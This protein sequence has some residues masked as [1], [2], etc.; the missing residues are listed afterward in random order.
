MH[1]L[2]AQIIR[3][4]RFEGL[5]GLGVLVQRCVHPG[6]IARRDFLEGSLQ[7]IADFLLD[8]DSVH[9]FIRETEEMFRLRRPQIFPEK[10]DDAAGAPIG[11]G[12]H[13]FAAD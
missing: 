3:V 7:T 5:E 4:E 12:R 11:F 2:R 13:R 6:R 8:R 10:I 9:P 1:A